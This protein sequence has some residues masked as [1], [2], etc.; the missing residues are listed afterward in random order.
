M[1]GELAAPARSGNLRGILWGGILCGVFDLTYAF[2][3]YGMRGATP[4]AILHSIASGL[5]GAA[6]SKG[7]LATAALGFVLHFV[8]AFGAA[9]VYYL[10]SRKMTF[11]LRHAVV[12][13][14]LYGVAVYLFMNF[15][16]LPLSAFPRKLS[17]P[18]GVL[19]PGIACHMVLVGL[20][21][22][23]A[24]RWAD[25]RSRDAA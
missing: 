23:L 9:T 6:A 8:I 15:L 10:A 11:L 20:P 19:I 25:A 2:I 3:Y 1:N 13:G 22:A 5:L 17:Y 21:I 7:G 18:P 14:L 12:C 24:I 16:V 4:I